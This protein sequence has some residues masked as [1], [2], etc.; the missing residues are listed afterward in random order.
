MLDESTRRSPIGRHSWGNPL[1]C[2]DQIY[3][4]LKLGGSAILFEPQKEI[5][6]GQVVTA[7]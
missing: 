1:S 7:R 5:D 6:L 4:I 2:F 3:R